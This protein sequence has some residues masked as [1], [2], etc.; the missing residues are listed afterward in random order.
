MY[1][2]PSAAGADPRKVALYTR[3][4]TG[5]QVDKESLPFQ[6]KELKAYCLHV[7]HIPEDKI[8]VYED[9]GHSGKNTARPAFQNMLADVRA[10]AIS[11]VIVYKI[12]RISRNLVDFSLMYEEFRKYRCTFISLNEQF[13]T[14]SAMGEAMLK[15]IL[16]FAELE[17]KITSERVTDIMIER[18]KSKQWNGA[19]VPYGWQ[20]D[21]VNSVPV[22]DPV[23]G[24]RVVQMYQMYLD[25]RST[26]RITD[27]FNTN[28]IPTKRGGK[29]TTKTVADIL[30]NPINKGDYRYNYRESAHG[31]KKPNSEVIYVEDVFPPL[32]AKDIW[33]TVNSTMDKQALTVRKPGA[34]HHEKYT[35][36]FQNLLVCGA[37]SKPF[38]VRK[39]D[40]VRNNG[41][42]PSYYICASK[43]AHQGCT[44]A[45]VG[46]TLLGPFVFNYIKNVVNASKKRRE[47]ASPADLENILLTGPEFDRV[48]GIGDKGLSE[49]FALLSG[50]AAGRG[51]T[52]APDELKQ[53]RGDSSDLEELK[54]EIAAQA[55][56]L[57]RLKKAY[58]YGDGMTEKEYLEM[59]TEFEH[60]KTSAENRLKSIETDSFKSRATEAAFIRSASSF[61]LTHKIQSG[62]HIIYSDFAPTVDTATMNSFLKIVIDHITVKDGRVSS[63]TFTNGIEHIFLYR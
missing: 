50:T 40:R 59:K 53:V 5:Y 3:V 34:V 42:R 47:I 29:W 44:A 37:C 19:R 43:D 63:I 13:D 54:R 58:F 52:Y 27:Y 56:A 60:K 41:F 24:P 51:L 11:H 39:L 15:I 22:H 57:E 35:H 33:N 10:G 48:A 30:R 18:A 6:Q 9:A 14:S 45:S 16:V 62:E 2:V 17:R 12:D 25:T 7:L 1:P 55:R 8:Q 46:D 21:S 26:V 36:V 4:S 32:I 31:R 61:L 23:E 28:N 49:M 20:W 38:H